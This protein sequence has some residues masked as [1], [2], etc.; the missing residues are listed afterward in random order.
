METLIVDFE[1][2][3]I[4]GVISSEIQNKKWR[5]NQRWYKNGKSNECEKY[6]LMKLELLINQKIKTKTNLRL[7]FGSCKLEINKNPLS[8][9]FG[10]DYTEDIDGYWEV[11]QI[12]IYLNLKFIC[13]SGGAQNR[14]IRE[15]YHFIR[16]QCEYLLQNDGCFVNILDGDTCYKFTYLNYNKKA[17]LLD[18]L[19]EVRYKNIKNRIYIGDT[20][21]FMNWYKS[22][23]YIF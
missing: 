19:D 20:Y 1:K 14:S 18:I 10:F 6:Q 23:D 22:N 17:S 3:F 11:N 9:K 15:V 21:N 13:D 7:N 4:A 16:L 8:K 5:I 12:N 2:L